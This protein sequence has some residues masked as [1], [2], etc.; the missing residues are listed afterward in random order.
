MLVRT[1]ILAATLP[2]LALGLA[3]GQTPDDDSTDLG[4]AAQTSDDFKCVRTAPI[5]EDGYDK[6]LDADPRIAKLAKPATPSAA[7]LSSATQKIYKHVKAIRG[8]DPE[9]RRRETFS[10][11]HFGQFSEPYCLFHEANKPVYGTV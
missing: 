8:I 7:A 3:C 10:D 11:S 9:K 5:T 4:E 1:R 2:L 6:I